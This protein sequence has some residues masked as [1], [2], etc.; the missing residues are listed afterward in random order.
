MWNHKPLDLFPRLQSLLLT[1]YGVSILSGF[2]EAITAVAGRPRL[3]D[4]TG[5]FLE[6]PSLLLLFSTWAVFVYTNVFRISLTESIERV[7]RHLPL[8]LIATVVNIAAV[9]MG[10]ESSVPT[11]LN[12]LDVPVSLLTLGWWPRLLASP[13]TLV[14]SLLVAVVFG[15]SVWRETRLIKRVLQAVLGWFLG[16]FVLLLLPSVIA[17]AIV[18]TDASPLTA[19]PN[20]LA[21]S[22]VALSQ[23]GYWWRAVVDRFPGVLEGEAESSV[24]FL[25]LSLVWLIGLLLGGVVFLRRSGPVLKQHL[26]YIKPVRGVS[27]L[28]AAFFGMWIG[29]AMGGVFFGRAI[30]VLACILLVITLGFVWVVS[31]LRNDLHDQGSDH[32]MGRTDRPLVSG[33]LSSEGARGLM[34]LFAVLALVSG[35]LLGWPVLLPLL[36]FL[37]LQELLAFPGVRSK[38][39]PLGLVFLASSLLCVAISGAFFTLRTAAVPTLRPGIWLALVL[40]YL[41]HTLPK[42]VRWSPALTQALG[43]GLRLSPRFLVPIALALSY[44]CVPLFSGW[45]LLW[46]IALPCAVVSLLPLL[47][48]GRWDERKIVG[49]QTAFILISFLLLSVRPSP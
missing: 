19:G 31:V 49:W 2:L 20:V 10:W 36:V 7:R 43:R 47:G 48:S 35:W 34:K 4:L 6:Y 5:V 38:E 45:M 42:V 40:F 9:W 24:R 12:V 17:W 46:W 15:W 23:E 16:I 25:R 8:A 11:F 22:W 41:L 13:G 28:M 32:E 26:Q 30:D 1:V 37:L 3:I 29:R 39:S 14:V 27:F 44:L 21:R 33:A 18:S